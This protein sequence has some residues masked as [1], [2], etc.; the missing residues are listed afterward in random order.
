[1][2]INNILKKANVS[3]NIIKLILNPASICNLDFTPSDIIEAY[4]KIIRAA[5]VTKYNKVYCKR[6]VEQFN[7]ATNIYYNNNPI[8]CPKNSVM[9]I[10]CSCET[11]KSDFQI[12]KVYAASCFK[13]GNLSALYFFDGKKYIGGKLLNFK[14]KSF[15]EIYFGLGNILHLNGYSW[16]KFGKTKKSNP[17]N[18]LYNKVK[19]FKEIESV[20]IIAPYQLWCCCKYFREAFFML[21]AMKPQITIFS[22]N[23]KANKRKGSNDEQLNGCEYIH[24]PEEGIICMSKL[25]FEKFIGEK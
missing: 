4:K 5:L 7:Q 19:Q 3:S 23:F 16:F 9:F 20:I 21:K 15:L 24:S 13:Y 18:F 8:H 6:V 1:M 11:N 17:L 22:C 14:N 12:A 25:S 10:D 2:I